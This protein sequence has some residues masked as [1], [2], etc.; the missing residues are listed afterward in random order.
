MGPRSLTGR[1]APAS[2]KEFALLLY[3]KQNSCYKSFHWQNRTSATVGTQGHAFGALLT[4][5]EAEG[6]FFYFYRAQP[7]ENSRFE[8]INASKR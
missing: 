5:I 8:K 2:G 7:I 4:E 1:A 3:G 6:G